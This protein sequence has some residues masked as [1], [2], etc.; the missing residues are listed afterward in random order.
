MSPRHSIGCCPICG[1]GLCGIRVFDDPSDTGSLH[2]L[3]I[4]D[5]CDA[6]WLEPN[7][8]SQHQYPDAERP[9]SP[10]TGQP[11]WGER[12]RWASSDEVEALG[13]SAAVDHELDC[14]PESDFA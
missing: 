4:C 14:E 3:I 13:W 9:C 6:I 1:G 7:L 2:G 8:S 11:I 10:I 12:S 5:E